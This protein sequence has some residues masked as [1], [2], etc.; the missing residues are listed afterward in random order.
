MKT[1]RLLALCLCLLGVSS[2]RMVEGMMEDLDSINV[3]PRAVSGEPRT[4]DLTYNA[5]CPE[6][7][8]I[9][10]LAS[11]NEFSDSTSTREQDLVSRV[12]ISNVKSACHTDERTVTLDLK[13]TFDAVLGAQARVS[14]TPSFFSY[15]FFVAVASPEGKILAKE[16][17]AASVSF[18]PGSNRH[19]YYENI[20]Q[21]IPVEAR[22][23]GRPFKI[24]LG[25]QLGPEQLEYNRKRIRAEKKAQEARAKQAKQAGQAAA[26][27]RASSSAPAPFAPA[28]SGP[29]PAAPVQ[30]ENLG[31]MDLTGGY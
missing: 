10:E 8:L 1:F 29:A 23:H 28:P 20:R 6:I 5:S 16:V 19:L 31:P 13:L 11:Y 22:D 26:P 3:S 7:K 30:R 25:F 15:P 2:C 14:G 21:L 24:M 17:F 12:K 9:E 27:T 4:E 18:P